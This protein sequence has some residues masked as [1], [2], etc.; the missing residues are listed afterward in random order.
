[1]PELEFKTFTLIDTKVSDAGVVEGYAA[2]FHNVDLGGD[3]I[4]PGAFKESLAERGLG[5]VKVFVGHEHGSLPV[6]RPLEIREDDRGLFTRTQLFDSS[7]GQDVVATAKG[8]ADGAGD[9]LGMS[10]G[11]APLEFEFEEREG[12][13]VRILKRVDMPEYS[14][15]GMPMNELATVTDAKAECPRCNR[16][17][18]H[19]LLEAVRA[20]M[21]AT[22]L[23]PLLKNAATLI[24]AEL[25]NQ[26]DFLIREAQLRLAQV[27]GGN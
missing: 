3:I 15:V 22:D 7:G 25:A 16:K 11:Y 5:G 18:G 8:L 12:Q 21:S 17:A 2:H 9:G 24:E 14:Y 23:L 4:L 6:G 20:D 27:E 19:P 13:Q 1:M 10:I 26:P